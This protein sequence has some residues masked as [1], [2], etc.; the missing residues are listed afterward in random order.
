MVIGQKRCILRWDLKG[1]FR[2]Q[3]LNIHI[4]TFTL[5]CQCYNK[6]NVAPFPNNNID[7]NINQS[8]LIIQMADINKYHSTIL[9][10][11]FMMII[12]INIVTDITGILLNI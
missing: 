2:S 11:V 12:K 9:T 10:I 6:V 5:L 1:V 7:T 8:F 3:K 4:S